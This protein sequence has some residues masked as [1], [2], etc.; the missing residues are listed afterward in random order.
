[1]RKGEHVRLLSSKLEDFMASL[2]QGRKD[3][4]RLVLENMDSS[5]IEA[6]P[7]F[8]PELVM[9]LDVVNR[10]FHPPGSVGAGESLGTTGSTRLLKYSS[11]DLTVSDAN[12]DSRNLDS[13]QSAL[14]R[15]VISISSRG[16]Y[17]LGAF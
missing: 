10:N 7:N 9:Y 5:Y 17:S 4:P 16:Y 14:E 1:M 11:V 3:L 2:F 6:Q 12:E 13:T 15:L 8:S